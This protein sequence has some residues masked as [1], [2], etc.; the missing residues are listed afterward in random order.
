MD[1]GGRLEELWMRRAIANA[2]ATASTDNYAVG[3]IVVLGDDVLAEGG[4]S[5]AAGY[6]PSAHPEMVVIRRAAELAQSRYL[7][8]AF[9]VTTLEPCVMCTG[10]AVWA[11]MAG[12]VFGARQADAIAWAEQQPGSALTWRQIRIPASDVVAAGEPRLTLQGDVLRAD[13]VELF[14]LTRASGES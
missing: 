3:A 8:G 4:S 6:D 5:L 12:I 7:E 14:E 9:L 10:A 2:R 1:D 11:K 13:C